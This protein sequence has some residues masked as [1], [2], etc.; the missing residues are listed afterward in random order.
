VMPKAYGYTGIELAKELARFDIVC[1]FAD[2]DYVVMML[3]PENGDDAINSIEKA[4][5]SIGRR[6]E[7]KNETCPMAVPEVRMSA[8]EAVLSLSREVDIQDAIGEVLASVSVSCPPAIPIAVCGEVID[9]K[10]I[11]L[12]RYYGVEKCRIVVR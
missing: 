10:V 4:F 3:T 5:A 7:I 8:R 1:E 11:E 9:E 12:F 2:P 6:E